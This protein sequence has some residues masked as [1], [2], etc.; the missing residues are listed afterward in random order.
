MAGFCRSGPNIIEHSY[1]VFQRP[2][3]P[4]FADRAE[5]TVFDGVSLGSPRGVMA[6]RNANAE[7]IAQLGLQAIFPDVTACPVAAT[8]VGQDKQLGRIGVAFLLLFSVPQGQAIGGK[9]RRIN[10]CSNNY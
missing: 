3:C 6:N 2:A 5:K 4:V 8:S 10:G 1:M 7:L 9:P